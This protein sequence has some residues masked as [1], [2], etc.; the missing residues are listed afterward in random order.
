MLKCNDEGNYAHQ[1]ADF[2]S[3]IHQ[4]LELL[5]LFGNTRKIKHGLTIR[6]KSY[7]CAI[8]LIMYIAWHFYMYIHPAT[9]KVTFNKGGG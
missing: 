6:F 1:Y 9:L 2:Y 3:G 7:G 4:G 8:I 5:R